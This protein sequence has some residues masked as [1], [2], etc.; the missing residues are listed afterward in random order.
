MS[1]L[2]FIEKGCAKLLNIQEIVDMIHPS[3]ELGKRAKQSAKPFTPGQEEALQ[4]EYD[5]IFTLMNSIEKES[6]FFDSVSSPLSK[7]ESIRH[8]LTKALNSETLEL[9]EIYE[10]KNFLFY[11][12]QVRNELIK[13]NLTQTIPLPDVTLLFSYLDSEGQN[14][15]I[16]HLSSRYSEKLHS[17]KS[18]YHQLKNRLT[19]L[20]Q[21]G[22]EEAKKETGLK[23][24]SR[25]I[26]VSRQN[27]K[28]LSIIEKSKWFAVSAENFANITFILKKSDKALELESEIHS[29]SKKIEDE[30]L[31]VR[32]DISKEI[33]LKV[34]DIFIAQVEMAKLDYLLARAKFGCEIKGVKPKIIKEIRTEKSKQIVNKADHPVL[35]SV[36]QSVNLPVKKELKEKNNY[37]HPTFIM[38]TNTAL[39]KES[40][41]STVE[42]YLN[43]NKP[44]EIKPIL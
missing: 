6:D 35:F 28:L 37:K 40:N 44:K 30:E 27:I 11:Y 21:E 2:P 32:K 25:Q 24:L 20:E 23:E 9:Q 17:L 26:V 43:T 16:F 14:V 33:A 31:V 1:K 15:P 4:D 41:I 13:R 19:Y 10:I 8:P 34:E 22:L 42:Y 39:D 5:K 18:E 29:L 38:S 7:M 12:Q 3:S 36:C